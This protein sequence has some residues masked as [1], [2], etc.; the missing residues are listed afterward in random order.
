[1][2]G[3]E[4]GKEGGCVEL[5]DWDWHMYAVGTMYKIGNEW[6]PTV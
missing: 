1:M 6:E 4:G 3:Y 2:Y 5:G